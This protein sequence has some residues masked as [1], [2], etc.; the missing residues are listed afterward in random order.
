[1]LQALIF[2]VDG[3]LAETEEAHRRAFNDAFASLNMKDHWDEALYHSL[4]RT[5]GGRERLACYLDAPLDDPVVVRLHEAANRAYAYWISTGLVS[6]R[7]GISDLL[8]RA[9]A[10][11]F[12]LAIATTSRHCN[13]SALLRAC[14]GEESLSWFQV[15]A[16]GEQAKLKKPSPEIYLYALAHLGLPAVDCVAFE[17]S[18]NGL[19][20]A[21]GAGLQVIASPSSYTRDEDLSSAWRFCQDWRDIDLDQL[22]ADWGR[23]G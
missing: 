13:V 10:R 16:C 14:L 2:D 20:A 9:R 6:L 3:T 17:D 7:P 8:V 19:Q 11:G 5:T 1:M 18:W 4:H 22:C 23:V 12:T 21:R 15:L